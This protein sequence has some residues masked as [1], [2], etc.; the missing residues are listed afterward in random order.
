MQ[1]VN[2]RTLTFN[3]HPYLVENSI[4]VFSLNRFILL[5]KFI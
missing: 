1:E 4:I 5:L 2:T 3:F